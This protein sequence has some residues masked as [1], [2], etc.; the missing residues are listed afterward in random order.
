MDFVVWLQ[1]YTDLIIVTAL[2]VVGVVLILAGAWLL[3]G[4]TKTRLEKYLRKTR[5]DTTLAIFFSSIAKWL[6][7]VLA[8]ISSF[9]TFGIRVTSLVAVL[10]AAGL[11]VGLALQGTLSNFASGVMLLT[12]RPFKVGDVIKVSGE[13]GRVD[14]IDLIFTRLD[15]FDNRRIVI[16][17]SKVFGS[18]IETITYHARR[19][20]DVPVGISYDADI[21]QTRAALERAVEMIEKRLSEPAPQVWLDGFGESSVNWVVRLWVP[22]PE[23]GSVRQETIRAIK[24]TLGQSGISIPYPHFDVRLRSDGSHGHPEEV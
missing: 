18:V 7:L 16:P 6:I 2:Q 5:L 9:E 4:W 23:F 1:S 17:N 8:V 20:V 12:F 21:D 15:T 24:H 11:A 3:S 13:T 14:E 10:G 22:S 19:R